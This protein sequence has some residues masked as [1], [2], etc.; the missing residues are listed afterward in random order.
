ML[1]AAGMR[2]HL[3][4]ASAA[5]RIQSL[6]DLVH[7]RAGNLPS[8]QISALIDALLSPDVRRGLRMDINRPFGDGEDTSPAGQGPGNGVVD[9]SLEVNDTLNF[10]VVTGQDQRVPLDS[11]N[12]QDIDGNGAGGEIADRLLSRQ[13]LARHL[14]VLLMLSTDENFVFPLSAIPHA[15]N[16]YTRGTGPP[17]PDFFQDPFYGEPAEQLDDA[18]RRELKAKRLAQ[19]AVNVV[20]FRDA[21]NIMTGFEFDTNPF[22]G[23][24]VD[25]NLATTDDP[26]ATKLDQSTGQPQRDFVFG[27]EKPLALIT[28]T[29]AFHDRR[30]QDTDHD[31]A[32]GTKRDA[33]QN[34]DQTL[35]QAYIPRGSAFIEVMAIFDPKMPV[36]SADLFV[37][38]GGKWLLDLGKLS[39]VGGAPVWRL[40][41]TE[42]HSDHAT[43][44][45]RE[46]VSEII[47]KHP[48]TVSLQPIVEDET[49]S[50]TPWNFSLLNQP[51]DAQDVKI[52]RIVWFTDAV[53][54]GADR[55]RTFTATVSNARL[56]GFQY[57]LVGPGGQGAGLRQNQTLTGIPLGASNTLLQ[58]QPVRLRGTLNDTPSNVKPAIGIPVASAPGAVQSSDPNLPWG[59]DD[60]VGFSISEPLFSDAMYYPAPTEQSSAT[61]LT[62]VYGVYGDTNKRFRD[63]PLD[64]E[65]DMPLKERDMLETGTYRNVCTVFLQR[66]ADPTQPFHAQTNPNITVD[67]KPIDLTVFNSADRYPQ[68]SQVPE[69]VWDPDD[70]SPN[71]ITNNEKIHFATRERGRIWTWNTRSD[72]APGVNTDYNIWMPESNAPN[73]QSGEP[74][75]SGNFRHR[76]KHTL[77]HLNRSYGYPYI[78]P[79]APGGTTATNPYQGAPLRPFPWI[80]WPNR[81]FTSALELMEVPAS[82]PARLGLEFHYPRDECLGSNRNPL[83]LAASRGPAEARLYAPVEFLPLFERQP[84]RR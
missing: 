14:Y 57:A 23:W 1:A 55:D 44:N 33:K 6:P 83:C 35:D 81:P 49:P 69:K 2:G 63:L 31:N 75:G 12:G 36:Q 47:S 59:A 61:N 15:I 65:P 28:E 40:A 37:Y 24:D 56:E 71:S 9:D 82:T 26:A 46:K 38:Q 39:A 32:T 45:V 54:D 73:R 77:G 5:G 50:R 25:G 53:P 48:D 22:D 43:D 66:L 18:R 42:F 27:C 11:S 16:G 72:P 58:L 29:F 64:S 76:L 84:V 13:L 70:P 62:E 34:P 74:T 41:V 67:C 17:E 68:G 51:P 10:Q 7:A 19:W 21:D 79:T 52:E 80:R 78:F 4:N 20:D 3:G 60:R 30:V 8:P